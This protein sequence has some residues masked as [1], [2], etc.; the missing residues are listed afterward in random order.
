MIELLVYQTI[1]HLKIILI[2]VWSTFT[3]L[4]STIFNNTLSPILC[5]VRTLFIQAK[6][7]N[8]IL[9]ILIFFRF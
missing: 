7:H 4:Y 8:I 9:H 6:K 2:S 5:P 3:G 1:R